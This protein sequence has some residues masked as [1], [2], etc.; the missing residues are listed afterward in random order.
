MTEALRLA[1][2]A[3]R[4]APQQ[5]EVVGLYAELLAGQGRLTEAEA[6][7]RE[8][9]SGEQVGT[10]WAAQLI[11][12]RGL[13]R[14]HRGVLDL[15]QSHPE[16]HSQAE[17]QVVYAVA[18]ASACSGQSEQAAGSARS[19][20]DRRGLDVPTRCDLTNVMG[21]AHY[22]RNEFRE[23]EHF[24][25][26]AAHLPH[27]EA[28]YLE[29]QAMALGE[30]GQIQ[31]RL[32]DL[33]QSLRLRLE[34]GQ[35]LQATRIHVALADTYLDLAQYGR[36][37][38]LLLESRDFLTRLGPSEH[39][40]ECEYR[41]SVLYRHWAPP[42][43]GLFFAQACPCRPVVCLSGGCPEQAGV[44]PELRLHRRVRGRDPG[45]GPAAG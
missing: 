13:A 2:R 18:F 39:L 38:D 30:Q 42:H 19:A 10:A 7:L 12:L 40:I 44:G 15:W 43:G 29:N 8:L 45:R 16:L 11:R 17:P 20:L 4:L 6:R 24:Y 37:E 23:A 41:L 9:A 34:C 36:A 22:G 27:L 25:A 28:V 35:L 31:A 33:E 1:E 14:D 32:T 21:T 3:Y 26:R 5:A